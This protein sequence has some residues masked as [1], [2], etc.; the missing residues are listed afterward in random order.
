MNTDRRAEPTEAVPT[1]DS[2]STDELIAVIA[3][4]GRINTPR[5]IQER[6]VHDLGGVP[7]VVSV[8]GRDRRNPVLIMV[9]GGPGA[10]L[11]STAWMWQRPLEESF[12]V[13]QYDQ[14]GAGRS[15]RLIDPER[16]SGE[17][18]VDRYAEDLIELTMIIR[19]EFGV[20]RVCLAGHSWGTAVAT[21]AVLTRPELYSAYLGI[22]Q[23]V[24]VAAGEEASWRWVRAEAERR[25]DLA[26]QAEL[27]AILP[28]PGPG[29]LDLA[30][31]IIER[32]WVQRY[33]GFAAGRE[34]CD[35][36]TDGDLLSPDDDDEDRASTLAGNAFTAE[37]L[38]PTLA[39]LDLSDVAAFPIPIIQFLGR[40]DAMTPTAP[41]IDWLA[42]LEAPAKI[43]E[44]F[45]DSAH[46]PMFEEPGH[47]LLAVLRELLPYAEP[48]G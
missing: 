33:G 13:V 48:A 41:V 22:G 29:P 18:G 46:M 14:R 31:V 32:T 11:S 10:P 15:Y 25:G 24:S 6:R 4:L 26:A 42:R 44:W 30:K 34:D 28:Y 21:R 17:L 23:V 19:A 8:R 20:N 38:L 12:T 45:E 2:A 5:G 9:H 43:I 36:F 40:H 39:E 7:Q 16:L 37:H 1:V 3:E 27:D 47:F 35:Y